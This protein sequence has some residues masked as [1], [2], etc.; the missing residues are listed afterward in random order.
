MDYLRK[1][2]KL[3]LSEIDLLEEDIIKLCLLQK[4]CQIFP[5]LNTKQKR[6]LLSSAAKF[7]KIRQEILK[8]KL[9]KIK[10][11]KI[12]TI[13]KDIDLTIENEVQIKELERSS[14][15]LKGHNFSTLY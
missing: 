5:T 10:E 11:E 13:E 14:A 7:S 4:K 1:L 3:C 6:A 15:I 8:R 2:E 9:E 12:L